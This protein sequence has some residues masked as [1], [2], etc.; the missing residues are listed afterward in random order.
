MNRDNS[1]RKQRIFLIFSDLGL[2]GVQTKMISLANKLAEQGAD[3]WI[4]LE[5]RGRYSRARF[6]D[7]RVKVVTSLSIKIFNKRLFYGWRFVFLA[8]LFIRILNPDSIFVSLSPLA[9]QL[10]NFLSRIYPEKVKSIL[11]NEDT[12]PSLKYECLRNCYKDNITKYYQKAKYVIAVSKSTFWDLRRNF[13][14]SSPPLVLLPNWTA[15]ESSKIPTLKGRDIDIIYAG[16]LE[17][18]K[19]P[20]LLIKL[21]SKLVTIKPRINIR[22]YGD[23]KLKDTMMLQIKKLH[24]GEN[25]HILSP[26]PDLSQILRRTRFAVFTSSYEGLPM[27]GIEAMKEGSVV[28]CLDAPGLRDLVIDN[29]TG[30]VETSLPKLTSHISRLLDHPGDIKRLQKSAYEYAKINFSE[31]NEKKLISLILE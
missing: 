13:Q 2:G 8:T 5:E 26:V 3:C 25:V 6:L 1:N 11:V 15:F 19:R 7:N 24:L 4:F 23:G 22:V 10:I 29:E 17:S 31:R 16:R 12:Y 20:L 9:T 14:I 21:F 27:A 30:V 28:A 18:Q